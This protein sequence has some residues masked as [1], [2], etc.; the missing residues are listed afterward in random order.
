MMYSKNDIISRMRKIHDE[1]KRHPYRFTFSD[2]DISSYKNA[3]YELSEVWSDMIYN[4]IDL[5]EQEKKKYRGFGEWIHDFRQELR[6]HIKDSFPMEFYDFYDQ[7]VQVTHTY[8]DYNYMDMFYAFETFTTDKGK[9]KVVE[10]YEWIT[11]EVC[12]IKSSILPCYLPTSRKYCVEDEIVRES[13]IKRYPYN[14]MTKERQEEVFNCWKTEL[15][16]IFVWIN[17]NLVNKDDFEQSVWKSI[18]PL[19]S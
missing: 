14:N 17:N 9:V 3:L 5:S 11:E 4:C 2:D 6:R 7:V 1:I 8:L 13:L 16:P 15:K 18:S 19:D 12:G 10:R